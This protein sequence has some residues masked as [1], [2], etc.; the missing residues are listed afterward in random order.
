MCCSLQATDNLD[1]FLVGVGDGLVETAVH[2]VRKEED[3]RDPDP[4]KQPAYVNEAVEEIWYANCPGKP[5][6]CSV[7]GKCLEGRCHC[8][9][10]ND[11]NN[12]K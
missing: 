10:G 12:S 7:R 1:T 11:N 8:D 9:T 4:K 5:S 6:A 3:P 2:E